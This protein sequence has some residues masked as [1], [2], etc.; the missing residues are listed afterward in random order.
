M[1]IFLFELLAG[2]LHLAQDA[3]QEPWADGFPASI[4]RIS[5]PSS[6][7]TDSSFLPVRA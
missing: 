2:E 4:G 3:V 5:K 1:L 6:S 7:S